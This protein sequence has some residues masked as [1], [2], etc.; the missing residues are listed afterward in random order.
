VKPTSAGDLYIRADACLGTDP[1]PV[2]AA[3]ANRC[4]SIVQHTDA[5][6]AD[7]PRLGPPARMAC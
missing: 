3:P 4:G 2:S 5:Y 6:A 7:K 1:I